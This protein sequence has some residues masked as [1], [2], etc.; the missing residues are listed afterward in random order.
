MCLHAQLLPTLE[1]LLL[2]R[3]EAVH[4]SIGLALGLPASS[5]AASSIKEFSFVAAPG[6]VWVDLGNDEPPRHAW[7]R[8]WEITEV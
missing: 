6:Y 8:H 7:A 1:G 2:P 5:R 4:Q 3:L